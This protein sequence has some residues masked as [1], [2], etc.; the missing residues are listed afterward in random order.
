MANAREGNVIFVDTTAAFPDAKSIC[1]IK[2]IG[3]STSS[4]TIR[5]EGASGGIMW[6][7]TATTNVFDN[8]E[9]RCNDG[10]H[11]TIAGTAGAYIYLRS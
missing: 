6:A 1:G 8:V 7:E 4:V 5:G 2:Y 3:A 9:I 11:V 10:I